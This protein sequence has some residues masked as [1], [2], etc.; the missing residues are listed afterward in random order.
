MPDEV[1]VVAVVFD[2]LQECFADTASGVV[3][4]SVDELDHVRA[5]GGA[6]SDEAGL[7]PAPASGGVQAGGRIRS[8]TSPS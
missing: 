4:R 2:D 8:V 1:V 5:L 7:E 6:G 3:H